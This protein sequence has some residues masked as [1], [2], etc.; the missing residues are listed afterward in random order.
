MD[1]I[2]K[3]W[4]LG[5]AALRA[6]V[7]RLNNSPL[8][9]AQVTLSQVH[10]LIVG[11]QRAFQVQEIRA[12]STKPQILRLDQD[13]EVANYYRRALSALDPELL[14]KFSFIMPR[15]VT[16]ANVTTEILV[17][18]LANLFSESDSLKDLET[19]FRQVPEID[20][21][22]PDHIVVTEMFHVK[23]WHQAYLICPSGQF[24]LTT[25]SL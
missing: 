18:A 14:P 10:S 5:G 6:M 12:A 13:S 4:A 7:L 21:S 23:A 19:A 22:R 24:L 25:L 15:I 8:F 16:F 17:T 9:P 11:L 1:M 2:G 3:I 20:A